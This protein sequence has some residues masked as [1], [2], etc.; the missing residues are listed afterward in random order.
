M[1]FERD[2]VLDALGW[3]LLLA[4]QE[5][6]RRSFADLAR[7]VNLSPP[8]VAER[9]RRMEEAGIITGYG[10]QVDP[11][12]I[13][14]PLVVFI[15]LS[16]TPDKYPSV[17]R[18][19]SESPE[20]VECHHVAGATS[21]IIKLSVASLPHLE[22]IIKSLSVYGSTSSHIVLSTPVKKRVLSWRSKDEGGGR[23]RPRSR[24][25]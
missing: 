25:R 24:S 23:R 9:V 14:L 17:V 3:Q 12:Q 10:A 6:A 21:F 20:I 2:T 5:D 4:L 22:Q 13:G 15:H 7:L 19:A 8:A 16:T 1:G 18:V 11:G